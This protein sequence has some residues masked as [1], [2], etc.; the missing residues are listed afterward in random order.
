[1]AD[2]E[3]KGRCKTCWWWLGDRQDNYAVGTCRRWRP[4]T[5]EQTRATFGCHEHTEESPYGKD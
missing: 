3:L 1:M 5:V 4:S 2:F